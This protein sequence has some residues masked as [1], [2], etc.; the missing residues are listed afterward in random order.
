MTRKRFKFLLLNSTLILGSTALATTV[1]SCSKDINNNPD[2]SS[3]SNES[4]NT[5]TSNQESTQNTQQ[6][7]STNSSESQATTPNQESNQNTQQQADSTNSSESQTTTPNQESTQ[8]TQQQAE[9]ATA[10]SNESQT[11]QDS[12]LTKY[13]KLV[14]LA[15][16]NMI[17]NFSVNQ[18][19]YN[20]IIGK[21]EKS[22]STPK[23]SVVTYYSKDSKFGITNPVRRFDNFI[24][25]PQALE[26]FSYEDLNN[27]KPGVYPI[28]RISDYFRPTFDFNLEEDG[29]L[30]FKFKVYEIEGQLTQDL[31]NQKQSQEF[32]YII[33]KPQ[34]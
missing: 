19:E 24:F 25:T 6:A 20:D 26:I 7:D 16:Q 32:K 10:N 8:N 17:F 27:K 13:E 9:S 23:R 2:N 28:G 1:V 34:N 31:S 15:K 29:S 3:S 33:A 5:N 14:E 22:K 11:P 4:Q 18:D 12:N 21:I 30:S